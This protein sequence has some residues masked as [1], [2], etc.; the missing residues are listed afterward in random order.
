MPFDAKPRRAK[1]H[2]AIRRYAMQRETMP[3]LA[4]PCHAIS[5]GHALHEMI[6]ENDSGNRLIPAILMS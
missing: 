3:C 1:Q 4:L 5:S 2:D 6:P